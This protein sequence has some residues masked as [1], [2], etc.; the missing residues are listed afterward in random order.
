V[1]PRDMSQA[2]P[3]SPKK[4]LL[5]LQFEAQLKDRSKAV[6]A[7]RRQLLKSASIL[8]EGGRETVTVH[9]LSATGAALEVKRQ[10]VVPDVFVL[11][12][13]MEQRQRRCRVAWRD[14]SRMGVA[15]G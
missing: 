10:Q 2:H 8:F 14:G 15:F 1:T 12:L 11:V 4:I 13:E 6:R 5:Q 3:A 9:N 7:P